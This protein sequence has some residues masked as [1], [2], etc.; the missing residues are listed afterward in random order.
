MHKTRLTVAAIAAI[1]LAFFLAT[2]VTKA[3]P[4]STPSG[5]NAAID[6]VNPLENVWCCRRGYHGGYR[7]GYRRGY[8]RYYGGRY[9]AYGVGSCWRPV[10]PGAWVWIC[11]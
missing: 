8:G 4:L 1:V 2:N 6:S 7:Y 3:M 10:G 5:V 11:H 9:W